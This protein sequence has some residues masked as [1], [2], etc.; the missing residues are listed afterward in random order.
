MIRRLL[1]ERELI[2]WALAVA[3]GYA[4]FQAASELAGAVMG[5]IAAAVVEPP[6][7][8]HEHLFEL[9]GPSPELLVFELGNVPV[10]YGYI[11]AAA[12]ATALIGLVAIVV[13]AAQTRCPYCR[14]P[15][16]SGAAVC[17]NCSLDLGSE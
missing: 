5:A 3:F 9:S 10:F 14:T 6:S 16:S 11:L 2:D 4:L 7:G 1:S 8:V 13:T 12:F 15:I 17:R